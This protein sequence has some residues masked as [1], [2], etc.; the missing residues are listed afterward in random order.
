MVVQAKAEEEGVVMAEDKPEEAD[1]EEE[2]EAEV[3]AK[4]AVV[5]QPLMPMTLVGATL[6]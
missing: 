4:E 2:A 6:L 3:E 5:P 1:Q